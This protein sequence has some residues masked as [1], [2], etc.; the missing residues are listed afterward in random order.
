MS[1]R[2]TVVAMGGNSMLEPTLPPTVKNQFAMTER[3]M[4]PVADLVALGE[5]VVLT[6]GNGPQVGFMA[7]RSELS[8]SQVHEVPLDSLV[9]DTQGALGYMM[10]RALREELTRRGLSVQVAAVVTE[11]EVDPHDPAF[12]AP[13]KPIGRFYTDDEM[14]VL[15]RERGW[16]MIEDSHRGWRRVVPSPEPRSVVQLEVVRALVAAGVV[17]IACGG[18]GI[19]VYR[20][21]D[22]HIH[23]V[24]GVVDKDH[25]SALLAHDLGASRLIITTGVDGV[26]EG[27][28]GPTPRL[29]TRT[30]VAELEAL[31]A[32]GEFPP[33]S[34]LPKVQAARRF[35]DAPDREVLICRPES[36]AAAIAGQAGTRILSA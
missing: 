27:F 35:L 14:P 18:G 34:M 7:L 21:D 3:A 4:R 22:G 9:A 6:H 30:T 12:E 1:T 8:R 29:L 25:A 33:G 20:D 13:T 15:V 31:E 26:Y 28:L 23:G 10:Q 32:R 19:P 2:L 11:V 36:L 16:R 17:P 24:E 5:H